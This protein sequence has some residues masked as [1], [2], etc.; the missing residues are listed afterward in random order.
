MPEISTHEYFRSHFITLLTYCYGTNS[1]HDTMS[2]A[3]SPKHDG[4][5]ITSPEVEQDS[6]EWHPK[7]LGDVRSPCP[8]LNTLANH[9]YL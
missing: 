1:H 5:R 4:E 6:H 2:A 8:A 3:T 7:Q 9:G